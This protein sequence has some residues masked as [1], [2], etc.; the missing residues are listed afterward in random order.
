MHIP[1][2]SSSS[3]REWIANY[4][5]TKHIKKDRHFLSDKSDHHKGAQATNDDQ[6]TVPISGSS[7]VQID[8]AQYKDGICVLGVGSVILYLMHFS[9]Q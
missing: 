4:G 2:W 8:N 7:I 5:A 9:H 3:T 6:S 1:P